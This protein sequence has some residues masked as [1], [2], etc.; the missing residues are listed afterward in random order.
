MV[1]EIDARLIPEMN[2]I[3][4]GHVDHGKTSLTQALSG[5]WTDVHSEE[6]K[7]GITLRLGYA[8]VTVYFCKKCN[9]YTTSTKCAKCFEECEPQRTFSII[10]A[11]GHETL[12]AT[13]LAGSALADGVLFVIAA[14]EECPQPQTKEHLMVLDIAGIK[15]VVI[16]Q[17]KIDLV[18]E[19]QALKNYKQIK[20]LVKGTMAE[21]AQ[22]IPVSAQQKINIDAL[23]QAIQDIPVP[24]RA[25]GNP[26]FLVARSFDVNKPGS[27]PQDLV[28]G[29][30]GG[31]IVQGVLK[32]EDEVEICPG[33]KRGNNWEPLKTK[34]IGI[35]KAGKNLE[36]AGAG[37]LL[38]LL[39]QLDPSLTKADS[40]AGNVVGLPRKLPPV[41]TELELKINLLERIVGFDEKIKPLML[42]EQLMI[43]VGVSKTVGTVSSLGKTVI[44]K[45]KL[46]VCC[47][48]GEKV[49]LS[50]R[51]ADRWRLIGWGS[52]V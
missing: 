24:K 51:I 31:S 42:N 2:L 50:R 27:A 14:N 25:E 7:R 18:S 49:A 5:K 41:R 17:T 29:I 43:I 23:L 3:T 35:Q 12:M 9:S 20:N 13:V 45:L 30:L 26:I 32:K 11:P 52:V 4:L 6:R 33:V 38:G 48:A 40:L 15:N 22:I 44:V 46:P 1:K 19:E 36:E 34:I 47:D 8:D 16:V 28:G 39:T 37:G 21:N 10:D